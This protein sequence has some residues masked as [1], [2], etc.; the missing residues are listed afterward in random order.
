MKATIVFYFLLV[1]L[2]GTIVHSC[3]HMNDYDYMIAKW[4]ETASVSD[5]IEVN[6]KHAGKHHKLVGYDILA[7][8][9]S[10]DYHIMTDLDGN[11]SKSNKRFIIVSKGDINMVTDIVDTE[12][13]EKGN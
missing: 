3:A 5:V 10:L 7:T 1:V 12:N 2:A 13:T 9:D 4:A 8:I 6:Q 11:I